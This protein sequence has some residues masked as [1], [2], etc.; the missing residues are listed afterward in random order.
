MAEKTLSTQQQ[1][2]PKLVL[3]LLQ[4]NSKKLR[5]EQ[6]GLIIFYLDSP[7]NFRLKLH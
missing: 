5:T 1:Q 3:N 7:N 4:M 6:L 2:K